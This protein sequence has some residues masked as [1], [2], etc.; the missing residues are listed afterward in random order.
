MFKMRIH[1]LVSTVSGS[2]HVTATGFLRHVLL[3]AVAMI[4]VLAAVICHI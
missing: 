3:H 2:R 4:P 1:L